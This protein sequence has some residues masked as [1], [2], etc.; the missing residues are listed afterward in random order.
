[1]NSSLDT[2][3]TQ[4]NLNIQLCVRPI[5]HN[6]VPA[7]SYGYDDVV[8]N[9]IDLERPCILSLNADFD[10][11]AHSIWV[12]FQNKNYNDSQPD[13]GL[14]MAVE[15]DSVTIHDIT[16]DRFK[17]AGKYYPTYPEDYPDKKPVLQPHTYLGWNGRWV[18]EFDVPVFTWIHRLENLGWLYTI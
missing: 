18:L 3:D 6:T 16:L 2:M 13:K 4:Y 17:W 15:I 7:I 8:I 10:R 9:T 12:D 14:D 5:Y 11:G 1:M